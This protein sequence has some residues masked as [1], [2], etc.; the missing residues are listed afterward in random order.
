MTHRHT[1][2]ENPRSRGLGSGGGSHSTPEA[3]LFCWRQL[4]READYCLHMNEEVDY[5]R[6]LNEEAGLLHTDEQGGRVITHR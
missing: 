2:T 1:D 3:W 4:D 6:Q 5:Y